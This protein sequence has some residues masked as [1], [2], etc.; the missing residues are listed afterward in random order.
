[1]QHKE[2]CFQCDLEFWTHLA[3]ETD[4]GNF[5]TSCGNFCSKVRL[6]LD[7]RYL[8]SIDVLCQ[9]S[10]AHIYCLKWLKFYINLFVRKLWKLWTNNRR[11]SFSSKK[12]VTPWATW[13]IYHSPIMFFLVRFF[14][15]A[16]NYLIT[17]NQKK[18]SCW[19]NKKR[20]SAT[21]ILNIYTKGL[22]HVP[23]WRFSNMRYADDIIVFAGNMV[24]KKQN[25]RY[26]TLEEESFGLR[27]L[28]VQFK[29]PCWW[30]MSIERRRKCALLNHWSSEKTKII[31]L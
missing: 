1:M 8:F 25:V 26:E 14:S 11:K 31:S 7:Y 30:R 13:V 3:F 2:I 15:T 21:L 22:M 12:I 27:Y 28:I 4:L 6:C 17:N 29:L 9:Y 18:R 19:S 16:K 23:F 10:I 24:S 20:K 5:K